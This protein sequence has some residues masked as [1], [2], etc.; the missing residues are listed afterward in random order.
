MTRWFIFIDKL[1]VFCFLLNI[2]KIGETLFGP[3]STFKRDNVSC[4]TDNFCLNICDIQD[5]KGETSAVNFTKFLSK[6]SRHNEFSLEV[7]TLTINLKLKN[8]CENPDVIAMTKCIN[9]SK[10]YQWRAV[11]KS[12]TVILKFF[13]LIIGLADIIGVLV[14]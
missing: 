1:K 13:C 2:L 6:S 10:C 4:F 8:F 5:S 12:E 9:G 7:S 14:L 3:Y 11:L